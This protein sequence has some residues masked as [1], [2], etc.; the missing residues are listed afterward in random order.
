M[1]LQSKMLSLS[2]VTTAALAFATVASASPITWGNLN[3]TSVPKGDVGTPGK[4]QFTGSHQFKFT[5]EILT[6]GPKLG[7]MNGAGFSFVVNSTGYAGDPANGDFGFITGSFNLGAITNTSTGGYAAITPVGTPTITFWDDI[8]GT[9]TAAHELTADLGLSTLTETIEGAGAS[10]GLADVVSINL[11]NFSH[12]TGPDVGLTSLEDG[13][14]QSI[15]F[16][17]TMT[18]SAKSL[19]QL[20]TQP[21]SDAFT[22]QI[23]YAIPD[24]G[25]TFG[26]VALGLAGVGIGALS[27]RRRTA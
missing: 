4:I 19:H 26:L 15:N 11:T 8:G 17:F 5:N 2:L 6:S 13:I 23:S 22:A 16:T 1:N 24:T 10:Y 27:R 18:N 12:Y 3:S 7:P 14:D 9:P 21:V 20:E 25:A